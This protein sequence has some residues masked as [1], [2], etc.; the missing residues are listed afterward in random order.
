MNSLKKARNITWPL[1]KKF[2]FTIIDDTDNS[3]IENVKPI[4]EYL[5][6]K[7]IKTTKTVW[8]YP[9]RTAFKG[10]TIQDKDYL[11]FL[12]K[13]EREGFEIQLHNIGSG[14]FKRYEILLGFNIFKETFGRYPTLQINHSSNPDNIYWG[15]KRYG[16][17]LRFL[18]KLFKGKTRRFYGDE[19]ESD[20]FWGDLSKKNIKYIRNRVFNGINTLYYDPQMPYM[21]K[22]KIYSNYWFSSSDGHTV[23][24]FN[25][26]I[27]KENID[28]L[29]KKNGLCIVYTHFAEG[30]LEQNGEVN[31]TFRENIDYL[32]SQN[33]WFAP[34]SE[35]LDHLLKNNEK[36]TVNFL[37][38]NKL[39]LR[40]LLDR[41]IKRI[42][43]GR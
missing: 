35:I 21:E 8:I 39:D 24:E 12:L 25:N 10:Q 14:I 1:N 29:I 7:N 27:T 15:Y 2:A 43:F 18:I 22:N 37:Y 28:K 26:L 3:T 5:F 17:I 32:S 33:G 19:I 30:F 16:T 40:W 23:E 36:N 9:S 34:A 6:S 13:I 11:E 42:K 4:Y 31:R 41:I 20:Y 38:I